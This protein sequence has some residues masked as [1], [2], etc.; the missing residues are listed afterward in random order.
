MRNIQMASNPQLLRELSEYFAESGY[1]LRRLLSLLAKTRAYARSG[2]HVSGSSARRKLRDHAGQATHR[3]SD[4]QFPG[5]C[6]ALGF[7]GR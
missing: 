2:V 5:T 3:E 1:N 4:D 6:R 7:G